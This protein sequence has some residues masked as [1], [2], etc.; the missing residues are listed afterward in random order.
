MMVASQRYHQ[1]LLHPEDQPCVSFITASGIYCY[2]VMPFGLKN[3]GAT[4][5]RM[6]DKMFKGQL[7]MSMEVSVDD[8]LVGSPPVRKRSG[9]II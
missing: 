3:A 7:G 1:I 6:V 5:Q 9:S 4:Y 2:T 8:M